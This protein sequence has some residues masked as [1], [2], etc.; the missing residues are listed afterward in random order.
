MQKHRAQNAQDFER[1]IQQNRKHSALENFA[2][3]AGQQPIQNSSLTACR[4]PTVQVNY[5]S[6]ADD[7]RR[8]VER[9][10]SL[11]P[12]KDEE[13]RYELAEKIIERSCSCFLWVGLVIAKLE[14]C[15]SSEEIKAALGNVPD[16]LNEL[17]FQHL[18][19]MSSDLRSGKQIPPK[20][21]LAKTIL[22]WAVCATRPLSVEELSVANKIDL[23]S[24]VMRDLETS[25]AS[26]C[27]NLV[28]VDKQD[29]V[30]I[31]HQTA[32][33]FLTD[34]SLESYFR[35]KPGEG[36]IQL[37]TACLKCLCSEE[38]KFQRRHRCRTATQRGLAR[39]PISQYTIGAFTE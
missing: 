2:S 25:I 3:P 4:Q 26:L 9:S 15:Y 34:D 12:V 11:L 21:R 7:I 10:R 20:T 37:A 19:A 13:T 32:R 6:N 29:L 24:D 30:Q 14:D 22:T 18:E 27:G 28:Y 17:C 35:I 1:V 38:M 33:A 8:Y 23:E 5:G 31:V 16:E 36:H 39:S